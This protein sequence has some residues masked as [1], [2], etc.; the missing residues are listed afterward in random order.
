VSFNRFL[1]SFL[2]GWPL[3]MVTTLTGRIAWIH[4]GLSVSEYA[5]WLFLAS[6]PV[7]V[8]LILVRGRATESIAHVL[9]QTERAGDAGRHTRVADNSTLGSA[10]PTVHEAKGAKAQETLA[11]LYQLVESIARR[12][13]PVEMES[14]T[15]KA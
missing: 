10:M 1:I 13:P 2:V 11:D 15:P 3:L 4:S 8:F 14:K 5:I 7:A 12:V 9:Y 6:A